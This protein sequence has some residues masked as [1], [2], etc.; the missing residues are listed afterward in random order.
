[1]ITYRS[2]DKVNKLILV[3]DSN[4][5]RSLDFNEIVTISIPAG[6]KAK[7]YGKKSFQYGGLAGAAYGYTQKTGGQ[8]YKLGSGEWE[9]A[10]E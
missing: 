2:V 1:M 9:I 3:A 10:N 7:E 8:P 5:E 4:Y 6:T